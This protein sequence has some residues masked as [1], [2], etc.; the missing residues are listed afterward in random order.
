MNGQIV[1]RY[2][3][4]GRVILPSPILTPNGNHLQRTELS[5]TA[6][7]PGLRKVTHVDWN[8]Q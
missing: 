6:M 8:G 7:E 2:K 4:L 3:R 1:K 5:V